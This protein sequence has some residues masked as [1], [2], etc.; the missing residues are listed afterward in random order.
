MIYYLRHALADNVESVSGL[1]EVG[2]FLFW[3]VIFLA[4]FSH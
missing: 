1:V 4:L 3:F 2:V